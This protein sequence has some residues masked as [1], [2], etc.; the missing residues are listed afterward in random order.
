MTH[1]RTW[2]MFVMLAG[3]GDNQGVVA[4][5]P[6]REPALSAPVPAAPAVVVDLAEARKKAFAA[7]DAFDFKAC[8]EGFRTA[9][10]HGTDDQ[11]RADD[12]YGA[13]CCASLGGSGAEA[14]GFLE[15]AVGLGYND[16]P[17]IELDP[18]LAAARAAPGWAAVKAR[19]DENWKS[20]ATK[21]MAVPV[22]AAIDV[23]GA[24]KVD[25]EAVRRALGFEIGKPFVRSGALLKQREAEIKKL[26]SFSFVKVSYVN[27]FGGPEAGRAY[28]TVDLVET[29]DT[30]RPAL[31]AAPTGH[32]PDPEGLVA[33]WRA[34]EEK[35]WR[36]LNRGEIGKGEPKCAVAHCAL[37][38]GHADLAPYEPT[39]VERVPA[40]L[41]ELA[42]VLA[43]DGEAANRA[44]AAFLL[45]YAPSA[46]EAAARLAPSIRDPSS[47][48][49][50][51]VLR[52][53]LGTQKAQPRP[54]VELDRVLE[55]ALLPETT[56]RNKALYLL[57]GVLEKTPEAERVRRR[58]AIVRQIGPDLV[59]S[60]AL[61][62]PNNRQPASEVLTLL[63][64]EK[65]DDAKAW[66]AWLTRQR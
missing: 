13:A 9:A 36:L 19:A 6:T 14:V 43:T 57:K 31:L 53:L 26:G 24:P 58:R 49:R 25:A 64:G 12:W 18:E 5:A 37:G 66:Q 38:F 41:D 4:K 48:V 39:F 47:L 8:A 65:H 44:A 16:A 63:S 33:Q 62:Q 17:S 54:I 7:Y 55:A 45:A 3:C 21:P 61:R 50:N 27:Y 30:R 40:H 56:D 60:A 35:A 52:V 20:A 46:S 22:L 34:Y 42:A 32:P 11:A 23:F 59:A 10:E 29:G 1:T 28:L 15:R 2:I 51:N